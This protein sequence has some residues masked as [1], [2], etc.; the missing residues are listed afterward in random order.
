MKANRYPTIGIIGGGQL[1]RMTIL[2]ARRMDIPVVV[3]TPEHPSPASDI[4]NDYIVGS[5]YD[6]TKIKELAQA[7]DVITFEIEHVDADT[8]AELE[9]DGK[10]VIPSSGVLQIIQDKSIQKKVLRD[11]GLPV[12][13]WDMLD[14]NNREELLKHYGYPVVQ[15]SCRGGYDGKGVMVITSPEDIPQML[16]GESF[17]E[18]WVDFQKEI[19]V[20]VARNEKG[21]IKA[22]PLV[23]M[24]F[25]PETNICDTTIVPSKLDE[26]LQREARELAIQSVEALNGVGI[27]GVEMFLTRDNKIL[28]NEIAPRPH[29]SGHYTIE[30]CIT[31]QY[32]Q[33]I[34]TLLNLPLG[35]TELIQPNVMIN[36]LGAEGY[37]GPTAIS[38]YEKALEIPGVFLHIYGKKLTKPH[39]KMGHL[40]AL[41]KTREEAMN[42]AQTAKQLITILSDKGE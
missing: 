24:E 4:A 6:K 34:R 38:G 22:Y 15:K 27:F 16:E 21:E 42:K 37:E 35:S 39:R 13:S 30:G 17:L 33:Y 31:S 7:C 8:L 12:S 5:L 26:Q 19:A 25:N 10:K 32:E 29:N 9:K 14:G 23:E 11:H 20:M 2:E 40:T 41:G 1:G 18:E 36:L 28:I 3:L